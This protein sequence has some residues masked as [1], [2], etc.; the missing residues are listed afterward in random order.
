VRSL[1]L[2][3]VGS[4]GSDACVQD[5]HLPEISAGMREVLYPGAKRT[6]QPAEAIYDII[7]AR[8]QVCAPVGSWRAA[9]PSL[10]RRQPPLTIRCAPPAGQVSSRCARCV[11]DV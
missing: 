7:D 8:S 4:E 2:D 1:V 3:Q 5:F 9:S 11:T 6:W 10:R